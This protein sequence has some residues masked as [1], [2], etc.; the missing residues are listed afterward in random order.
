MGPGEYEAARDLAWSP[1]EHLFYVADHRGIFKLTPAGDSTK[2][3]GTGLGLT[4]AE[5][6]IRQHEGTIH[7]VNRTGGGARLEVILRSSAG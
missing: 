3:T 4:V 2:A 1:T 5:G 6:I 7:A